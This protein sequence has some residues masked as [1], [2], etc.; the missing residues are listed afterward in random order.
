MVLVVVALTMNVSIMM[1]RT[2]SMEPT[3]SAGSIAFVREIPATDIAEGDIVTVDRGEDILPVTHRVTE[4]SNTDSDSGAVTFTMR[5]DANETPDPAPYTAQTVR[6]VLFSVPGVAPVIQWFQNPL[7]LGGLTIGASALVVWA[8]WPRANEAPKRQRGAHSAQTI[9]LPVMLALA[10]PLLASQTTTTDIYGDYLRLRSSGDTEKMTNMAPGD[11][12]TWVVDVWVDAPEPGEVELELTATGQLAEQPG[13]LTT[14]IILCSP[15]RT[16]ITECAEDS[17]VP[18]Q[19][20]TSHLAAENDEYSLGTMSSEETRRVLVTATL[21]DPP[22]DSIQETTAAFQFIATGEDE[23]LSVTPDPEKP[24]VS[25]VPTEADSED[26][27]ASTGLS[28]Q[29]WIIV[30]A[31]MLITVG[32]IVMSVRARKHQPDV[33]SE[34]S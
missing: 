13:A 28:L 4:I 17:V 14:E 24:D 9:A 21:A 34:L 25:P 23:Q 20:D 26:G 15:H 11:S 16:E 10:A 18:Q 5:G 30:V 31:A 3:I 27:L 33:D 19:I 6:R 22:P 29:L 7:V 2:G 12:A 8:F 1:F 32:V